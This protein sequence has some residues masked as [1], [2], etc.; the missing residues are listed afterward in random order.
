MS[1]QDEINNTIAAHGQWKQKLRTAIDTGESESTPEKV[2]KDNNC[3]FGKWIHERIEP[4]QKSSP[5]YSRALKLNSDFQLFTEGVS[6]RC[7]ISENTIKRNTIQL[8]LRVLIN[9]TNPDIADTLPSHWLP[10]RSVRLEPRRLTA[11]CQQ[12]YNPILT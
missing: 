11:S 8:P 4:S 5:H 9:G 2:C 10:P 3:S 1:I 7:F 12:G 6:A